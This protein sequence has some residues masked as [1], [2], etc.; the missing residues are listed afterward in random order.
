MMR[1]STWRSFVM[2]P[3]WLP[4]KLMASP[5]SSRMAIES[6]AIEMRSPAREQHVELAAVGVGRDLL[7]E[8]EQ[9]VGGIAHR[10]HDD[11]DVVALAPRAHHALGDLLHAG[12][13]RDARAAVL[14][15]DDRH[16]HSQATKS[17]RARTD[18]L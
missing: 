5:P 2:M 14:L 17:R 15:D 13:V 3:D 10:G 7:G 16:R 4:V 11:D 8:R 9:V 18:N 6:S 12:D 1:A